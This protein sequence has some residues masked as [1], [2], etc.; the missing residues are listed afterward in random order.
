MQAASEEYPGHQWSRIGT[1]LSPVSSINR[2]RCNNGPPLKPCFDYLPSWDAPTS[3]SFS[4]QSFHPPLKSLTSLKRSVAH[5]AATEP[6][7]PRAF[8]LPLAQRSQTNLRNIVTSHR[9]LKRSTPVLSRWVSSLEQERNEENFS[10]VI[11]FAELRMRETIERTAN[12]PRPNRCRCAVA[13]E[14]LFGLR[15]LFSRYEDLLSLVADEI[16]CSCYPAFRLRNAHEDPPTRTALEAAIPFFDLSKSAQTE[17]VNLQN[18]LRAV[19]KDGE[20]SAVKLSTQLAQS[21][22]KVDKRVL[23]NTSFRLWKGYFRNA[24]LKRCQLRRRCTLRLAAKWFSW[25]RDKPS[26][27]AYR[28]ELDDLRNANN[29]LL[30][31]AN[32]LQDLVRQQEQEYRVLQKEQE[33]HF[34]CAS[35]G[36]TDCANGED[37]T[38]KA[39]SSLWLKLLAM[40]KGHRLEDYETTYTGDS[41]RS[42]KIDPLTQFT[43]DSATSCSLHTQTEKV[44]AVCTGVQTDFELDN[45][46][47]VTPNNRKFS[48]APIS[49]KKRTALSFMIPEATGTKDAEQPRRLGDLVDKKGKAPKEISVQLANALIISIYEAKIKQDQDD[50]AEGRPHQPLPEV[51]TWISTNN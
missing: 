18:E 20:A 46:M 36:L 14:I 51:T 26:R 11:I 8:D 27:E 15:S 9:W 30:A 22:E 21:M 37:K 4:R 45:D 5:A 16:L 38:P 3:S 17:T 1:S 35:D 24:H 25:Y 28:N 33:A 50:L 6:S 44:E 7:T 48:F 29:R 34:E 2:S 49:P 39:I 43:L 13:F 40:I 47:L 10:S 31:E 42:K 12:M 23:R 41:T 32:E 19:Q